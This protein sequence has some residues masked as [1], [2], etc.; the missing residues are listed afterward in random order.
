[1]IALR[2]QGKQAFPIEQGLQFKAGRG[3]AR[4]GSGRTISISSGAVCFRI[5]AGDL[6]TEGEAIELAIEWP[7]LLNGC[8]LMTLVIH[9]WVE[10]SHRLMAVVTTE[11]YEFKTRG[12]K[13]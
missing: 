3:D 2:K 5:E 13:A 12:R 8:C 10:S 6:L 11:R 9:G 7:V 4:Q 1:M